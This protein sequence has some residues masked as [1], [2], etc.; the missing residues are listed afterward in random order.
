ML[1]RCSEVQPHLFAELA[2]WQ[3]RVNG[4]LRN[5]RLGRIQSF[6]G[7]QISSGFDRSFDERRCSEFA[8]RTVGMGPNR[9][10]GNGPGV[11]PC[12][13]IRDRGRL[14]QV[15][16]RRRK[17]VLPSDVRRHQVHQEG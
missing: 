4:G 12:Q 5:W 6:S 3:A 11:T 14:D 1:E 9:R 10:V 15:Y 13:G 16:G 17:G 7:G 2:G 8:E